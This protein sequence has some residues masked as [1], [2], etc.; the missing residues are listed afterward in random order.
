MSK[1]TP[2]SDIIQ[3]SAARASSIG[4]P[5]ARAQRGRAVARRRR[6]RRP[7][8][9]WRPPTSQRS[10][11]SSARSPSAD[12]L[13]DQLPRPA[14]PTSRHPRR[15]RRSTRV[16]PGGQPGGDPPVPVDER[17]RL[18][19]V[20]GERGRRRLRLAGPAR[21]PRRGGGGGRAAGSARAAR[22]SPG[23][24]A[25]A[26]SPGGRRRPRP[27]GRRR[28]RRRWRRAGDRRRARWRRRAPAAWPPG[29]RRRPG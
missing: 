17:A 26:A 25:R 27:A 11:A 13:G 21:A 19:Q 6:W 18:H 20:V 28:P 9:P 8:R 29:R 12:L 22:G 15:R 16:L 24:S 1:P 10:R 3:P 7:D 14:R 5:V 23:R 2:D 4:S